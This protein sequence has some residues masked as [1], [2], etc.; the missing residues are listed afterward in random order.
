MKAIPLVCVIVGAILCLVGQFSFLILSYKRAPSTHLA[1]M[2]FDGGVIRLS[3]PKD[4]DRSPMFIDAATGSIYSLDVP[5]FSNRMTVLEN[6]DDGFKQGY[7]YWR[8][9]AEVY[10][11]RSDYMN[12]VI[13]AIED[14]NGTPSKD[15]MDPDEW[16]KAYKDFKPFGV[17]QISQ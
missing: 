14:K 5:I 1:S 11:H 9:I 6:P 15:R 17:D 7:A 10:M 2:V 3:D 4:T 12:R 16:K 8:G 13:R